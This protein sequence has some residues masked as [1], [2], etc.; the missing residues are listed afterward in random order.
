MNVDVGILDVERD[1]LVSANSFFLGAL[2]DHGYY[3]DDVHTW[4]TL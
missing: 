2:H 1:K 4:Y 3:V